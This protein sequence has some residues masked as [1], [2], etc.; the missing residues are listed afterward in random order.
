MA[1]L[2]QH[3]QDTVDADDTRIVTL[4]TR[5]A[6]LATSSQ[7]ARAALVSARET[8]SDLE[9]QVAAKREA[10]AAAASPADAEVL[11][12]ELEA[13]IVS[14]RQSQGEILDLAET[15]ADTD[16]QLQLTLAALERER[17]AR[18]TAAAALETA[19]AEA[20]IRDA[21]V[22][23]VGAAPLS[24]LG[25]TATA[26]KTGAE[27]T[28]ALAKINLIPTSLRDLIE[29]QFDRQQQ[30]LDDA[31]ALVEAAAA[32]L[33]THRADTEGVTGEA[34][35]AARVFRRAEQ[36]LLRFSGS[37][38]ADLDRAL[39][40][41]TDIGGN[42]FLTT[43]ETNDVADDSTERKAAAGEADDVVAAVGALDAAHQAYQG[44]LFT[45]QAPDP[46]A[47]VS[48]SVAA[49][50]G[51]VSSAEGD[52]TT[53]Q[54]EL[55]AVRDDLDGWTVSIP[56][57]AW[58]RVRDYF[59]AL[60]ILDDLSSMPGTLAAD[61]ASA[62]DDYVGA[63]GAVEQA[64]LTRAYMEDAQ[65]LREAQRAARDKQSDLRLISS[66]RNDGF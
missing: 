5:A 19:T 7:S 36:A 43:A 31:G 61:L 14:Q 20:A 54:G 10:V 47:D 8:F 26:A 65:A 60:A 4:Q 45:A 38:Q 18:T 50:L 63:L 1:S 22:T 28:A 13:L 46:D 24:T 49:E 21:A 17:K 33:D 48:A 64:R 16:A 34:A 53:Q 3:W 37:G 56:D 51:A 55:A 9:D 42:D 32:A 30:R 2:K 41:L 15:A 27:Q 35:G 66:V 40:L 12:D 59:Q 23:A 6:S 44:A 52:V 39:A 11:L 25:A 29:H 62:E 57:N 58:R